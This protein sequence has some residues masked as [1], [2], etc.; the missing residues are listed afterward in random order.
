MNGRKMTTMMTAMMTTRM[1]GRMTARR[2]AMIAATIGAMSLLA[3]G[4]AGCETLNGPQA[5]ANADAQRTQCTTVRVS[6]ASKLIRMDSARADAEHDRTADAG[7]MEQTEGRL[8]LGH[9]KL[10]EPA[11]LA[12]PGPSLNTLTSKAMRE[13]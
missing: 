13:C 7:P 5:A 11:A 6:S 2:T 4:A 3:L 9:V 8:D 12:N 10:N 1:T